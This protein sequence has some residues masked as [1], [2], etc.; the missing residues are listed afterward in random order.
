MGKKMDI[1]T[2]RDNLRKNYA[3]IEAQRAAKRVKVI[4]YI[5]PVVCSKHAV[6][7]VWHPNKRPMISEG[8]GAKPLRLRGRS[9][10][11]ERRVACIAKSIR[12]RHER[13]GVFVRPAS[14]VSVITVLHRA[15]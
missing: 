10:R 4:D 8:A 11:F 3:A 1:S 2:A 9:V 6:R 15:N 14:D 5:K 13:S 7:R 12:C